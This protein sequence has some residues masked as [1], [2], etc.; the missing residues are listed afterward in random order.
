MKVG[1]L[2]SG[3]GGF[4]LGFERAGFEVAYQV[5]FDKHAQGVLKRHWPGVPLHEDVRNVGSEN[6]PAVDVL[7]GGFPC[8]DLSVAGRRAGL[9]GARS[10][11]FYEFARIIEE[12]QPTWV[13]IENV[14]GLLSSRGGRDMGAV[15]GTLSELGYGWAYRVLDS[16]Y[17]GVPQRRRRVFIVGH[18]GGRSDRCAEILFEPE[19]VCGNPPPSRTQGEAIAGSLGGGSGSRGWSNDLDRSG[20]FV[21]CP[22]GGVASSLSASLGHHGH[23]SPRG[24][25]SDNQVVA[26]MATHDVSPTLVGG[27]SGERGH[28]GDDGSDA[29][30]V[31]GFA[32]NQRGEVRVM[33]TSAERGAGGGKPGSGYSAVFSL[34]IAAANGEAAAE[35]G[36]EGTANALRTVGGGS[37]YSAVLAI[38]DPTGKMSGGPEVGLGGRQGQMYSLGAD[39]A[40]VHAVYAIQDGREIEKQQNGLGVAEAVAYTLDGTGA[41]SV[42]DTTGTMTANWY[43]G[44]GNTQVEMGCIQ[45]IS[46]IVRRLTP[47]ECERLQ[48]FP[49]DWTVGQA[50]SHRYKQMGNA[51]TVNVAEWLAKRICEHALESYLM[52]IQINS[53]TDSEIEAIRCLYPSAPREDILNALPNRSWSAVHQRARALSLQRRPPRVAPDPKPPNRAVLLMRSRARWARHGERLRQQGKQYRLENRE[54]E[55][56]RKRVWRQANLEKAN[57]A[58]ANWRAANPDALVTFSQRRRARI[59]ETQ[60]DFSAA[61]WREMK[62]AHEHHCAYCHQEKPLTQDH[63][64]PISKGGAHTKN[65][66]APACRSCNASK[67][68]RDLLEW[69]ANRG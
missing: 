7:V 41:Q 61:Q 8:Q 38:E 60:S 10:G 26:A 12:T 56:A 17:F 51:V 25:G 52:R 48:G 19:S 40:H 65:N 62:A 18:I 6:L 49:D 4:D 22:T 9:A 30:V 29:Y 32:E 5:E 24:D 68:N 53:W 34:A 35:L 37:S 54:R 43:K 33:E 3:V 59:T 23:S 28:R 57:L 39:P 20:A 58:V 1:S 16:Q 46:G 2:F 14:P 66:I 13:V 44:P 47:K 11:L 69:I 36:E 27:A 63:I 67:Y 64:V 55:A 31:A 15:L 21:E 50:D 42:A 45:P